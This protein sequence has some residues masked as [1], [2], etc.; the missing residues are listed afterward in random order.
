MGIFEVGVGVVVFDGLEN[1]GVTQ[2]SEI[3]WEVRELI[4]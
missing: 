1:G 2:Y 4:A 3:I